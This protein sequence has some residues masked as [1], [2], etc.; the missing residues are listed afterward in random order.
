MIKLLIIDD[1]AKEIE[2]IKNALPWAD[3]GIEIAGEALNGKEGYNE[4]LRLKPQIIITDVVMPLVDGIDMIDMIYRQMPKVKVIFI[5]CYDDFKFVSQAIKH[6]AY[7]YVLKP[8]LTSELTFAVN[9]VLDLCK[10]EEKEYEMIIKEQQINESINILI[11]NYYKNLLFGTYAN[12]DEAVSQGK[13]LKQDISEG[14]F[15]VAYI[16]IRHSD[17]VN[18]GLQA[19]SAINQLKKNFSDGILAFLLLDLMS[20]IVIL[21]KNTSVDAASVSD[22]FYNKMENIMSFLKEKY[23]MPIVCGLGSIVQSIHAI[24][25][26]Y[27]KAQKALQYQFY[28]SSD[29]I[30]PFDE[31]CLDF[32]NTELDIEKLSDQ[33]RQF[34]FLCDISLLTDIV[35]RYLQETSSPEMIKN[36]CYS[37]LIVTQTILIKMQLNMDQ[38]IGEYSCLVEQI[39]QKRQLTELKELMINNLTEIVAFLKNKDKLE[40]N[41]IIIKMEEYIHNNFHKQ[42]QLYDVAKNVFISPSY[43]SFIFKNAT[44]KT[45]HQYIEEVR[46][47]NAAKMLLESDLKIQ[48]VARK[49]GYQNS[50]YFINVFRKAY[51]RTPA[52]YRKRGTV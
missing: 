1:Q 5:S 38:I 42:I 20:V 31:M 51:N 10:A 9:K 39:N 44:G 8:I 21:H 18:H 43:A 23:D 13:Q 28:N 4:A 30:I 7:G 27:K 15:T 50:S 2:F 17:T 19:I 36:I 16:Q 25:D 40:Y 32:E 29:N 22:Y 34:I 33:I 24:S 35:D 26:S 37:I 14:F 48:D 3:M 47:S 6:G 45:V 49:N 52:E 12:E 41:A 11:D 46:I